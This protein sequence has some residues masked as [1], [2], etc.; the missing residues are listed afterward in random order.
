MQRDPCDNAN[1]RR[2]RRRW[3]TCGEGQR[4]DRWAAPAYAPY[5]LPYRIVTTD[6]YETE[7]VHE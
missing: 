3:L 7:R 2:V 5:R 6:T 1:G 4:V